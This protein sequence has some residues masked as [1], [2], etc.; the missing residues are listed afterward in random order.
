MEF[1]LGD[2]GTPVFQIRTLVA[3]ESPL[4]QSVKTAE[5]EVVL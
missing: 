1:I 5:V 4:Q 3:K 2:T